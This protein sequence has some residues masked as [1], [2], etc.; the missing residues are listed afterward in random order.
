MVDLTDS[1]AETVE[2]LKK[3][4]DE[5][6]K[7]T[8]AGLIVGL[9]GVF[10]WTGW[11][12]YQTQVAESASTLYQLVATSAQE[13]R[14]D[15]VRVHGA[16]LMEQ[17][18]D[19]GYAALTSLYLSKAAIADKQPA[20]ARAH[21][22]WVLDNARLAELK[23]VARLRLARLALDAG[24]ADEAWS[25]VSGADPGKFAAQYDAVK[26]D[27]LLAQGKTEDARSAYQRALDAATISGAGA[28]YQ[29]LRM[30]IDDLGVLSSSSK[31][32]G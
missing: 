8:A 1:D 29:R 30:K 19:S 21:L 14:M 4:W 15:D 25:L 24:N 20:E 7:T 28:E 13:D 26:G 22:Q 5:N 32:A 31:T 23:T 3:W 11:Q 10:G 6:G 9:G 18:P 2:K 12:S 27:I 17:F 16:A